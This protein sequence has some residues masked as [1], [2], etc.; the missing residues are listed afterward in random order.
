MLPCL[1]F[2]DED[3]LVV[4]KAAG[5]NTHAP[6]P[7]AGEGIYDWLR[8]REARWA[9]LAIVHRL[10][11]ESS[12]VIVFSK[13]EKANR[14]LTGQFADRMVRKRYV[15]VTDR[16]VSQTEFRIRSALVRA[17]NKYMARPA[18]ATDE[19]AETRFRVTGSERGRTFL[20]AQPVTGRTHQIR[21]HAAASGFPILGDTLY[22]GTPAARVHLHAREL[23]LKHPATGR[24]IT[25]S[26]PVDFA[27]DPRLALRLA[28]MDS[29]ESDSYR[30]VHGASDGWPG[31]YVDRLGDFLLSQ[32]ESGLTEPQRGRLGELMRIFSLQGACHKLLTRQ[33]RK[34]EASPRPVLGAVAPEEI[35]VLEN[36]LRYALRLQEGYSV[37]LFLDQRENRRRFLGGH[38]AAGFSL[39]REGGRDLEARI[40]SRSSSGASP[41]LPLA[42]LEILNAFAYTCGFSVCAARAGARTT[43][44]DL[45]R[46][47][48]DWGKQNFKLNGLDSSGHDFIY[49]EV[50]DWLH[51][52]EKR[53][54]RFDVVALDPP[55]FSQSKE[56]GVFQ[57]EKDFGRLVEA[58]LRVLKSDGALFASTN[59]AR[60][61]PEGFLD[62]ITSAIREANRRIVRRHYVPQ[63][64]D[65]PVTP[66]EPAYLKTA[67]LR[68]G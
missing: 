60:L 39:D 61:A 12:G 44:L 17:G 13:T 4:N 65:F 18:H 62:R 63:P 24:E 40:E 56:A 28:L 33:V 29:G 11:K 20:E 5:L 54:R 36:G 53:G 6:A 42:G 68:V 9:Q 49:G 3:L 34:S 55:T 38:V 43:S 64:P 32:S 66:G 8:H 1:I 10:D 52:F 16:A 26:A 7:Y 47:Y 21:A 25:F 23:T 45:S 31:W 22:G 59:A 14:S 15:V 46:K 27:A 19:P 67:W 41:S 57:A 51:R 2:E 58:A 50:F 37:G 48:L 30:L 35:V